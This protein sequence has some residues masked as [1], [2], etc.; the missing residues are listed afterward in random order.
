VADKQGRVH[1][2]P[3]GGDLSAAP[4][5]RQPGCSFGAVAG[6]AGVAVNAWFRNVIDAG[7][8]AA[9]LTSAPH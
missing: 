7:P 1:I 6:Y 9:L 8:R 5:Y 4:G 3:V 2:Q